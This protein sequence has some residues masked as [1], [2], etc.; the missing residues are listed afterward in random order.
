MSCCGALTHI[1]LYL[2]SPQNVTFSPAIDISLRCDFPKFLIGPTRKMYT[3]LNFL[4]SH[5]PKFTNRASMEVVTL[6]PCLLLLMRVPGA[7]FVTNASHNNRYLPPNSQ[8]TQFLVATLPTHL[9]LSPQNKN[10]TKLR[11][12]SSCGCF[13][14]DYRELL[15][16][17]TDL[18]T[19]ND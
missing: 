8:Q 7:T 13:L 10:P 2:F 17:L 5:L 12:F 15:R 14:C 1:Y 9:T 16:S 18:L 11:S 3:L 6:I 4:A 19:E